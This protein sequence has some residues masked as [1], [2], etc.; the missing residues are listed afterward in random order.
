MGFQALFRRVILAFVF[1]IIIV[2]PT[3]AASGRQIKFSTRQ[4]E[5][6]VKFASRN[7][8]TDQKALHGAQLSFHLRNFG[9][10]SIGLDSVKQKDW[11]ATFIDGTNAV[12]VD[13]E[14]VAFLR[15]KLTRSLGGRKQ[16]YP[17]AATVISSSAKRRVLIFLKLGTLRSSR[18][19][20]FRI[21]IPLRQGTKTVRASAQRVPESILENHYCGSDVPFD[22][23]SGNQPTNP[24]ESA[25]QVAAVAGRLRE[26]QIS[27]D[28]DFEFYSRFLGET[29]AEIASIINAADVIYRRDL[30]ITFRIVSQRAQTSVS[31]PFNATNPSQ[32]LNEYG[33]YLA[34]SM[35]S[36]HHAISHLFSGKDIDNNV[37]GIAWLAAVCRSPAYSQGLTQYLNPSVSFLIFAHEVGHNFGASHDVDNPNSIMYPALG[38][39]TMAEFSTISKDAINT[40]LSS[41]NDCLASVPVSAPTPA[42]IGEVVPPGNPTPSTGPTPLSTPSSTPTPAVVPTASSNPTNNPT[43]PAQPQPGERYR[44]NLKRLSAGRGQIKI[45]AVVLGSSGVPQA[46]VKVKLIRLGRPQKVL[47]QLSSNAKGIV[48]FVIRGVGNYQLQATGRLGTANSSIIKINKP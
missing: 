24:G 35:V 12:R 31:Q 21:Q 44:L 34:N 16:N 10:I 18:Q 14:D 20:V 43:T 8:A 11:T 3:F 47:K 5:S 39:D 26:A 40:H 23:Q 29:N 22:G 28:A 41:Y 13:P 7:I 2:D 6:I 9:L 17:L 36:E 33:G 45:R 19:S 46:G 32:L 25:S 42:P 37:V 27:T 38:P 15:G 1:V 4:I 30:G 48:E